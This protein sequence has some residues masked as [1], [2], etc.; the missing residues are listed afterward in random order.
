MSLALGTGTGGDAQGDHLFNFENL[1]GSNFDDTL[2]GNSG[3]NKLV[4]G[5]GIDTVSYAHAA[6]GA[7][8]VG[9]TVD[10]S[11]TKAQKTVDRRKRHP[12][13]LRERHRLAVQRH[14]EG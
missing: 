8:G 1:T 10:L 13:R 11:S 7:N 9:V 12:Q 14:P 6:S 5:A 3:N 4:G 2:E